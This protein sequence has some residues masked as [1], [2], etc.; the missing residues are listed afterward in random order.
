MNKLQRLQQRNMS[1]KEYR[2]KMELL[3]IIGEE[4]ITIFRFLSR[5]NLDIRDRFELLPYKDL[6]DLVQIC[7]KV[8]QQNLRKSF[9]KRNQLKLTLM[10]RKILRKKR[11]R[12][13]HL[14]I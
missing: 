5:L 2:Q 13:G 1:V 4:S 3:M 9:S 10:L 11:K 14:G 6:N 8:E 7:I 12:R